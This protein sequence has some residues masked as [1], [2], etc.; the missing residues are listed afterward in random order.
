MYSK[1]KNKNPEQE[2]ELTRM[3]MNEYD[4]E[5]IGE[6]LFSELKSTEKCL[7]KP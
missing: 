3:K 1:I 5:L 7:V 6:H 4:T 2:R